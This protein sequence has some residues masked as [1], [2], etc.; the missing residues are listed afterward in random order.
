MAIHRGNQFIL[1]VVSV[2]TKAE[3]TSGCMIEQLAI[4]PGGQPT[5]GGMTIVAT[6]GEN[7]SVFRG[8]FMAPGAVGG[9]ILEGILRMWVA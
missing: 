5:L 2:V 7:T 1:I 6:I 3:A 4:Q 9:S 8:F